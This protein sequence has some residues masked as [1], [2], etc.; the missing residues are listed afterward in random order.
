MTNDEFNNLIH[1]ADSGFVQ[2]T[3]SVNHT[4]RET[5]FIP[6]YDD[7]EEID[8]MVYKTNDKHSKKDRKM[9]TIKEEKEDGNMSEGSD[10]AYFNGDEEDF[11]NRD[12]DEDDDER[13]LDQ[14]FDELN[15]EDLDDEDHQ[16]YSD[17][18]DD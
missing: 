9:N 2:P 12:D 5:V 7:E 8:L 4:D 3:W 14:H 11:N 1:E 6:T 13:Q 15:N 16:P 18:D 10:T 17:G